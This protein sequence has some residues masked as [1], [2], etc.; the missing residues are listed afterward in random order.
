MKRRYRW[1]LLWLAV[2]VLVYVRLEFEGAFVGLFT[3]IFCNGENCGYRYISFARLTHELV[4]S[5]YVV[6]KI[7]ASS[8]CA[9]LVCILIW[10]FHRVSKEKLRERSTKLSENTE[11]DEAN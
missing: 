3:I 11:H 1:I 10:N 5:N 7:V 4:Q 9:L 8:F 2:F 6:L